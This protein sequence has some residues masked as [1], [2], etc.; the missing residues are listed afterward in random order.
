M[1][2]PAK[3][4]LQTSEQ[5]FTRP[6][7]LINPNLKAFCKRFVQS[8]RLVRELL[9]VGIKIKAA[10]PGLTVVLNEVM[11]PCNRDEG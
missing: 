10:E 9:V 5:H 2:R 4:I 6:C 1:Q 7:D 3:K 8:C 11:A